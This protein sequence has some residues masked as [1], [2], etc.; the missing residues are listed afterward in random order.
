MYGVHILFSGIF[1][2]PSSHVIIK[3]ATE[4]V[5]VDSLDSSF[6]LCYNCFL[7]LF[8]FQRVSQRQK[9]NET[10]RE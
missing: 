8:G 2:P 9:P 10:G 3:T 7:S 6:D 5:A 4:C 1:S